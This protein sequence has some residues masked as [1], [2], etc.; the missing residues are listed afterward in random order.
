MS[1]SKTAK[2]ASKNNPTARTKAADVFYNDKKVEP[3]LVLDG[4]RRYMAAAYEDGTMP[5]DSNGSPMPWADVR[6]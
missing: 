1:K 6:N 2:T 3:V 4:R 5:M